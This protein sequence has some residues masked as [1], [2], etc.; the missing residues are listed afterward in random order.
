[1]ALAT[2]APFV[3]ATE[4]EMEQALISRYPNLA[5]PFVAARLLAAVRVAE[6][7]LARLSGTD[8][9]VLNQVR[10]ARVQAESVVAQ[11]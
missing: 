7:E 8:S 4:A 9:D 10:L 6:R 1:M 11:C 5:K 2:S 3:P